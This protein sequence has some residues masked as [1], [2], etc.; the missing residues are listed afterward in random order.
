ML[1]LVLEP[2]CVPYCIIKASVDR[3]RDTFQQVGMRNLIKVINKES[4]N[5][6]LN[7]LLYREIAATVKSAK[8]FLKKVGQ[9]IEE[10]SKQ[11]API[12]DFLCQDTSNDADEFVTPVQHRNRGLTNQAKLFLLQ[13]AKNHYQQPY[14][15]ASEKQDLA[16]HCTRLSNATV[17]VKQVDAWFVNWRSRVWKKN[18]RLA[19]N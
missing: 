14:P 4:E 8:T 1:E 13:W 9:N 6:S 5:E 2:Q 16:K 15:S 19:T 10:K 18:V 3:Y 12:S 11:H 7:I 17:T